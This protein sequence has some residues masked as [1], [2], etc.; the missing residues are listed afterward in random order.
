MYWA[1]YYVVIG[2]NTWYYVNFFY[3][4]IIDVYLGKSD[5]GIDIY[6]RY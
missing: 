4:L 3:C 6:S 5:F 1:E 2:Y